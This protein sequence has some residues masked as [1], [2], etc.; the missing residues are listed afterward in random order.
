MVIQNKGNKMRVRELEKSC[1]FKP[2]VV[3]IVIETEDEF[4]ELWH[5]INATGSSVKIGASNT[6]NLPTHFSNCEK[7][8]ELMEKIRIEKGL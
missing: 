1:S 8:W 5:R 4:S 7:I 6:I 3:E 2:I